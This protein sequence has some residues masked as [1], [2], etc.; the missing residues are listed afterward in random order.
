MTLTWSGGSGDW[1]DASNWSGVADNNILLGGTSAYTVTMGGL[2]EG[3]TSTVTIDDPSAV[4]QMAGGTWIADS[5][6]AVPPD[7]VQLVTGEI[8]VLP[9]TSAAA[10]GTIENSDGTIFVPPQ[11]SLQIEDNLTNI[12]EVF[13]YGSLLLGGSGDSNTGTITIDQ[14]TFTLAAGAMLTNSGTITLAGGGVLDDSQKAIAAGN[15]GGVIRFGDQSGAILKIGDN[16]GGTFGSTIDSFQPSDVI[17]LVDAYYSPKQTTVSYGG[18]VLKVYNQYGLVELFAMTDLASGATFSAVSDGSEGIAITTATPATSPGGGGSGG[19]GGT[20][21]TGGTGRGSGTTTSGGTTDTVAVPSGTTRFVDESLEAQ[22]A[23]LYNAA[24]SRAPDAAGLGYWSAALHAGSSL[25]AIAG[26]FLVSPEFQ[27]RYGW[28]DTVSFVNALYQNILHR[29]ADSAGL[30]YWQGALDAGATNRADVL[31]NFSE[32]AENEAE[33]PPSADAEQAARLYWA[34]LGRAPDSVGLAF[35]TSQLSNGTA[36][37]SQDAG[38]L[39]GSAEFTSRYGSLNDSQFVSQL[40]ENVLGRAPDAAGL[41]A[42]L[43]SLAGGAS[44][45]SVVI[46]FTESSE[47]INRFAAVDGTS[48]IWVT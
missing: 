20:G 18:G 45:G 3:S 7:Q 31:A 8:Y 11:A 6:N 16:A 14:G 1:S 32:S 47:M 27:A 41:T 36:T 17:D 43:N 30:A 24:F 15:T 2:F 42:W 13:D 38:A 37:L 39:A 10:L 29:D 4:L 12:G 46:G 40:Y 22:A 23:R 44:R 21:G 5:V 9:G 19:S 35:W 28:Q 34:E 48:G 25:S 26:A 33:T